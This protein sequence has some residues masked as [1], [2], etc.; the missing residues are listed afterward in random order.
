APGSR[1]LGYRFGSAYAA[2]AGFRIDAA[3]HMGEDA[4]RTFCDVI[5]E[6]TQSIGKDRFLLVGEVGG[7]REHAWEVVEKTGL[8]AAL[9]IEDVPGKLERMVTGYTDPADYFSLFRN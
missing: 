3:K 6:F 8:D 1:A 2:L 7:S 4:L 5:R 9:G